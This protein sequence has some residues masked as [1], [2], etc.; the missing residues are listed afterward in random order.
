MIVNVE[1][2]LKNLNHLHTITQDI[3]FITLY[4]QIKKEGLSKLRESDYI[5]LIRLYDRE[6]IWKMD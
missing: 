6:I 4:N 3:R 2:I 1:Y 5:K